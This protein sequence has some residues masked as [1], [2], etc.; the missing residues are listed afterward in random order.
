MPLRPAKGAPG[1]DKGFVE[2]YAAVLDKMNM[3][4]TACFTVECVLKSTATG[5]RVSHR[6][7]CSSPLRWPGHYSP[8][9]VLLGRTRTR[10]V[11][12]ALTLQYLFAVVVADCVHVAAGIH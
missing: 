3:V 2:V 4:F 12:R 10:C 11:F 7:E 8:R 9:V 6:V 5:V 1:A